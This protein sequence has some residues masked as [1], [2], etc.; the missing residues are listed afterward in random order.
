M[1]LNYKINL[2]AKEDLRNIYTFGFQKWGV[3]Q[4][5]VYFNQ[6]FICF[7]KIC[8]NPEQFPFVNEIRNGYQRCVCGVDSIYFCVNNNTIEIMRILGSQDVS[9]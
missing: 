5:D 4:A 8:L 9:I 1:R 3:E 2:E 7:D 6:L